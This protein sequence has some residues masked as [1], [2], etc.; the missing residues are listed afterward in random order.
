METN[1]VW[2]TPS[3]KQEDARSMC[4]WSGAKQMW[5][6][7]EKQTWM[8]P[9]QTPK[10]VEK[11]SQSTSMM[12]ED[13]C[14]VIYPRVP[15]GTDPRG[16][17]YHDGVVKKEHPGYVFCGEGGPNNLE[18]MDGSWCCRKGGTEAPTAE[19][20][21]DGCCQGLQTLDE[22]LETGEN[23]NEK[24]GGKVPKREANSP[25]S[26]RS[27]ESAAANATATTKEFQDHLEK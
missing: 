10:M 24:D 26:V 13:E 8:G 22:V 1:T 6:M 5:K 19:H 11:S 16:Q 27:G 23:E 25:D 7:E 18:K 20:L 14:P 3:M 15:F 9:Q 21:R 4:Q 2:S 17:Y 12:T